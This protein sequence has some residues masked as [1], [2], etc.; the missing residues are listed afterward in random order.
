MP[1]SRRTFLKGIGASALMSQVGW[2]TAS[3]AVSDYRA[4]VCIYFNGG[5]DGFNTLVPTDD[6]HYQEYANI[7]KHL[8]I[9]QANLLTTSLSGRDRAGNT[10][11][12]G[13]HPSMEG[14]KALC[15]RGYVTGLLN[16]GVLKRPMTVADHGAEPDMLFSHNSQTYEWLRGDAI[17]KSLSSGWGSRLMAQLSQQSDIPPMYSF[18]G[19]S[20]L[21]RGPDKANSLSASGAQ[22][23]TMRTFLKN[24][25]IQ[26]LDNER[27]D[28]FREHF[29]GIMRDSIYAS[30][31]VNGVISG[32]ANAT[33][34]A[35]SDNPLSLQLDATLKFINSRE[36]LTQNR[37][38]FFLNLGGFDTHANQVSSHEA[39]L[40]Q[41]SR[42]V[43]NFYDL[44]DEQGLSSKVTTVT[45]SDFGRRI[46]PNATGTDHGWGNNQFVISGAPM[47]GTT[48]GTWPSLVP[49]GEDDFSAG[50]LLP[51][52]S[53]DQIGA[54]LARWMGVAEPDLQAVFPNIANFTPKALPLFS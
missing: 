34:A 11:E 24:R 4:L 52:T 15:D 1:I 51:T 53:V 13:L 32:A 21:F 14:L 30:Q 31:T 2:A 28:P 38:I 40:S 29:R 19:Q 49:G 18:A 22:T 10:V 3:T 39:L 9:P 6:T 41:F 17:N 48:V 20:R 23:I 43:K 44:L 54:T 8:A 37:Q 42:A 7:R 46:I 36:S 45:L 16:C 12:L 27:P 47:A 26:T 5:N 33:L 35:D 25:Y 50:R